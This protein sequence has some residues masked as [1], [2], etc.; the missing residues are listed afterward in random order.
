MELGQGEGRESQV[1]G[2]V[3]TRGQA[4]GSRALWAG[5]WVAVQDSRQAVCVLSSCGLQ[6]C[7][8]ITEGAWELGEQTNE[9]EWLLYPPH[10][11]TLATR[12]TSIPIRV[13]APS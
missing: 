10:P 6:L 5:K 2:A 13:L 12:T 8:S 11:L 9:W 4:E 3:G 7:P 1:R